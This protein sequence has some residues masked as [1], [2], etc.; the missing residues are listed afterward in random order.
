[1]LLSF[2]TRMSNIQTATDDAN[3]HNTVLWL[4]TFPVCLSGSTINWIATRLLLCWLRPSDLLVWNEKMNVKQKS[5][6]YDNLTVQTD[7]A[8]SDSVVVFLNSVFFFFEVSYKNTEHQPPGRPAWQQGRQYRGDLQTQ[9]DSRVQVYQHVRYWE[10][11]T[12]YLTGACWSVGQVV[13]DIT[14]WSGCGKEQHACVHTQIWDD[15]AVLEFG[16]ELL[17]L[18]VSLCGAEIFKRHPSLR[19][20]NSQTGSFSLCLGVPGHVWAV[21][22]CTHTHD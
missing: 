5:C 15:F 1:M 20:L 8:G 9:T 19:R 12:L 22:H 14:S 4:Q 2:I 21:H 7:C 3:N 13:Y 16:A 18:C 10:P 11:F 17:Q 6:Q